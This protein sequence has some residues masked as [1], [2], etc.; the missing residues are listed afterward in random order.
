MF[1]FVKDGRFVINLYNLDELEILG[2]VSRQEAVYFFILL[3]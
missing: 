3:L 1:E 2:I